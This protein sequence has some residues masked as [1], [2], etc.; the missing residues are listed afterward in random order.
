[1]RLR[2]LSDSANKG[3][4]DELAAIDLGLMKIVVERVTVVKFRMDYRSGNGRGSFEVNKGTD[5]A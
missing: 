5:A 2:S 4:F 3:I 1:M